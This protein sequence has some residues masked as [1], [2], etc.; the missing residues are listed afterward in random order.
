MPLL[1]DRTCI[2]TGG[3][4]SVGL[5]SASRFLSEGARVML[6]DLDRDRLAAAAARL[7]SDCV[8]TFTADVSDAAAT[9]AYVEAAFAK[10]GPIDVLFSNAGNYGHIGP[11]ETYDEDAFDRTY[12]IHVRGAFLAAK[13]GAPRM[14]DGGSFII[15]SSLAGLH[16]GE[17]ADR[18]LAYITAKHAQVGLMRAVTRALAPR[19]IRVNSLN[20][21][22]IDN[23]FQADIE[24][25]LSAL[26]GG[27]LT[28]AIDQATP[29]GRHV[30]PEEVADFALFL[31]SPMSG[32]VTGHVH[33]VDGGLGS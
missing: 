13:Y 30:R 26:S 33:V 19:G 22:A 21:G 23:A 3:C 9:R 12:R 17:N 28:T 18:N 11:L 10:W 16:G 2:I 25:R 29:L 31:A 4:G 8:A 1:Q 5:A 15:T 27:D 32:F 7:S 20:P 6:V 14:R 24:A